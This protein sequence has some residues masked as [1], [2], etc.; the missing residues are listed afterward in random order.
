VT[1]YYGKQLTVKY[2]ELSADGIPRF[3]I[4]LGFRID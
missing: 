3:P 4:G 1:D 2:Q